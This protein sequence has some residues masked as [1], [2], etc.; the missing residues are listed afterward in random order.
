MS[1]E[2]SGKTRSRVESKRQIMKLLHLKGPMSRTDIM[3]IL[4]IPKPTVTRIIE[5]LLSKGLVIETGYYDTTVGRKPVFVDINPNAYYCIGVNISRYTIHCV[6]VDF[7]LNVI[8]ECMHNVNIRTYLHGL[9]EHVDDYVSLIIKNIE[10]VINEANIEKDRILGIGLGSPGFVNSNEGI[11][12]D[13]ALIGIIK[14]LPIG[15][16]LSRHFGMKVIIDNNANARALNAY[17][18]DMQAAYDNMIFIICSEGIGS[19]IIVNGKILRGYDNYSGEIGHTTVNIAGNRCDCGKFGCLET[20]CSQEAIEK[21][22]DEQLKWGKQSNLQKPVMQGKK[23]TFDSICT[24]ACE[25]DPLCVEVFEYAAAALGAGIAN[26]L[27]I[28]NTQAVFLSGTLFDKYPAFY[29]M[30]IK[31]VKSQLPPALP[32]QPDFMLQKVSGT[33]YSSGAAALI[34]RYYFENEII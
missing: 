20:Y 15:K 9:P 30:V 25:G 4:S 5:E 33:H 11:I 1:Q 24:F 28:H 6:L 8:S 29:D 22:V 23:I 31:N 34:H 26:L 14:D 19:G 2:L 27:A 18:C 21:M 12:H 13:F 32:K 16:I 17:W 3:K 7:K 10:N